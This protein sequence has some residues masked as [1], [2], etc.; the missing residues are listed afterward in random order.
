M[1][2]ASRSMSNPHHFDVEATGRQYR[3][4]NAQHPEHNRIAFMWGALDEAS[5][6]CG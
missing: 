2:K 4:P 6:A 1:Q 3:V 5:L